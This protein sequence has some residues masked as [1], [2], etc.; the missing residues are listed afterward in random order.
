MSALCE[1]SRYAGEGRARNISGISKSNYHFL[2]ITLGEEVAVSP[3]VDL[4]ILDIVS[5][6]D[7]HFT[8]QGGTRF[9][10]IGLCR[11]FRRSRTRGL[12][13]WGNIDVLDAFASL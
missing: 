8:V 12:L 10:S 9:M 13:D 4:D 11:G 3:V 6:R 5:I 1:D 7:V 2:C